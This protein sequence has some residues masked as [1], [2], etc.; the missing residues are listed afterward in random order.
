MVQRPLIL[1]VAGAALIACYD[2]SFK[3]GIACGRDGACPAGQR[4]GDDV[5]C[6]SSLV[7]DAPQAPPGSGAADAT[8]L[9]VSPAPSDALMPDAAAVGC[10]SNTDCQPSTACEESGTCNLAT[11]TCMFITRNCS[12][13]ND[14]CN[15]GVCNPVAGC[16]KRPV[17]NGIDCAGGT[18]CTGFGPC[19]YSDVC[20]ENATQSRSC[21][22]H[23]CQGGTC[24]PNVRDEIQGCARTTGGMPCGTNF[25]NCGPC[26]GSSNEGCAPD[27]QQACTCDNMA[28][29][30]GACTIAS[31]TSCLRTGCAVI[32]EGITCHRDTG[33]CSPGDRLTC[34]AGGQCARPCGCSV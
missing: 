13:L 9:D 26:S 5:R 2:P 27:G 28:C 22:D 8:L 6:H 24:V 15:E 16:I 32:P 3:E 33:D 23:K 1:L 4:C 14:E 34:C 30:S 19:N 11:H 25:R 21:T 20:A 17:V 10:Q 18:T 29:S 7:T 31:T 12:F